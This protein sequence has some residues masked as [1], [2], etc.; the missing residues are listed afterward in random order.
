[1]TR[2]ILVLSPHPD[3]EAIGCGGALLDHAS[4]GD[5]T[6]VI[7]LSS[8]EQGG[9]GVPPERAGALR[10]REAQAA[11]ALLGV[12]GQEFWRQPDGAL[13]CTTALVSRLRIALRR[14][15]PQVVYAPGP[16]EGHPDHRSTA[17]LAR[18]ALPAGAELLF[19]EVWTPLRRIDAIVDIT[20]RIAPKIA[21]V[22]AYR[23]Q[24]RALRFDLACRGLAR[25][26][27][28][29]FC[30]PKDGGAGRYAEVFTRW[31]R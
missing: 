13:R 29:M 22:R 23:S 16:D 7:Y 20:G 11:G 24:C 28:E 30:W 26:R 10:E 4:R 5:E 25:W 3:D 19:Y 15:R 21:A 27:G 12:A 17:R 9:H 2:R 14:F 6:R 8:G 1:M 18:A 31:R